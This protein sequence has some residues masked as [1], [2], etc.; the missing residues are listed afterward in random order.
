MAAAGSRA[1]IVLRWFIAS[2]LAIA[3]LGVIGVA[4]FLN[5]GPVHTGT[6]VDNVAA[7]NPQ[8]VWHKFDSI[9]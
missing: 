3:A 7:L 9:W 8:T 5:Q 1:G 2:R 4:T 6:V